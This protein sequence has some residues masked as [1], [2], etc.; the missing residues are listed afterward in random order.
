MSAFN[1]RP[2]IHIKEVASG[3]TKVMTYSDVIERHRREIKQSQLEQAYW[4]A[5]KAFVGVM[6]QNFVVLR[7]CG[8][9]GEVAT[10]DLTGAVAGG[11]GGTPGRGRGVWIQRARGQRPSRGRGQTRGG[12]R[13]LAHIKCYNCNEMG[14]FKDKCTAIGKNQG[15]PA[16]GGPKPTTTPARRL[17][18]NF[19]GPV[20]PQEREANREVSLS[21]ARA[22][23][24]Y[25]RLRGENGNFRMSECKCIRLPK[26]FFISKRT[27]VISH[28]PSTS[29]TMVLMSKCLNVLIS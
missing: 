29:I 21:Q 19:G 6:E 28:K 3:I 26:K 23:L 24:A 17:Q 9:V 11:G 22:H 8:F 18:R 10:V 5:G 4:R 14:H 2:V 15:T 7:E 13:S 16:R 1:S 25:R 20:G 27:N 12:A